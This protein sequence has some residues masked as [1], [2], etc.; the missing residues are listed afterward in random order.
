MFK[1]L[2]PL[3]SS[4][5]PP[6]S[7]MQALKEKDVLI[8]DVRTPQEVQAGGSCPGSINVPLDTVPSLKETLGSD[9]SRPIVFYCKKGIRAANAAAYISQMGF[10]NCFSATDGETVQR[11]LDDIKSDTRE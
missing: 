9:P 2:I 7:L 3:F 1:R 10:T 6:L 5:R 4:K 11:L 8:V